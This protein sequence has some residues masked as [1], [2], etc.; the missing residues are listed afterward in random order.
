MTKQTLEITLETLKTDINLE[1]QLCA[2]HASFKSKLGNP[3]VVLHHRYRLFPYSKTLTLITI[4]GNHQDLEDAKGV[5]DTL[6]S[7][8]LHGIEAL[9]PGLTDYGVISTL[10]LPDRLNLRE[11]AKLI[12]FYKEHF[13]DVTI[14][15]ALPNYD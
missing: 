15:G 5:V 3:Y 7:K 1:K 11:I 13:D 4:M 8:R 6:I 10:T 14:T 12:E 2:V 9:Q